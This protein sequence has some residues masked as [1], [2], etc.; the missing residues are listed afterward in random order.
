M[1]LPQDPSTDF[2]R[3]P[4][5][6]V[7]R[8][9]QWA[10][11]WYTDVRKTLED[12]AYSD[13]YL[14]FKEDGGPTFSKRC[15][16][17]K[18]HVCSDLFHNQEQSPGYPTGDGD[19]APPGCDCGTVPCG[20]Y[21]FNHS[22]TTVVN[23]QSFQD[24]FIDSYIFNELGSSP[25]VSGFFLDDGW[26]G[27][28]KNG[29]CVMGDPFPHTCSDIGLTAAQIL[30]LTADFQATMA[31]V[32]HR[33]LAAGKFA[34]QF[35][36]NNEVAAD[37]AVAETQMF[38]LVR[39]ATCSEDLRRFCR[40]DSPT[41]A[42]ASGYGLTLRGAHPPHQPKHP[43]PSDLA[44][45]REDLAN[46]LLVRGPYAWLGHGWLGCSHEY[47]FPPEF[48][49]DYG[50]PVGLCSETAPGTG[51]FRRRWT[52]A[53]VEMDCNVFKGAIDMI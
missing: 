31:K 33:I 12:P 38:P 5:H 19:C 51:V 11:P 15:D 49:L 41:Q 20:F 7:Y 40:A 16:T 36:F 27:V 42:R 30:Q 8:N 53:N 24:W 4:W 48:N 18:P 3:S 43:N 26:S 46:F 35:L 9:L 21:V 14:K 29:D 23:G 25:L 47:P 44:H 39:N 13:W 32:R 52:K 22:T 37:D 45:V 10:Y 34:W 17:A 6:R 1:V 28:D 2:F 50:Q